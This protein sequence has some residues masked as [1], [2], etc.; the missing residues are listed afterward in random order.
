MGWQRRLCT[1]SHS[2]ASSGT[3][4]AV[5]AAALRLAKDAGGLILADCTLPIR[6]G[7]MDELATMQV[8]TM[9]DN[10]SIGNRGDRSVFP[11]RLGLDTDCGHPTARVETKQSRT[12][13]STPVKSGFRQLEPQLQMAVEKFAS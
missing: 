9:Y 4:I 1:Y 7:S 8:G 2:L 5:G 10:K 6:L 11:S 13:R 12:I 3:R